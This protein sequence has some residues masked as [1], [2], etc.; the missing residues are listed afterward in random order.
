M[1]KKI[2]KKVRKIMT[3]LAKKLH[4]LKNS[5]SEETATIYTTSTECPEPN[6]KVN[7]DG[8]DGYIKLGAT[9]DPLA[10]QGRV[11]LNSDNTDYA[12]LSEAQIRDFPNAWGAFQNITFT[13]TLLGNREDWAYGWLL[14]F[15]NGVLPMYVGKNATAPTRDDSLYVA[16]SYPDVNS[17]SQKFSSA[18]TD[19]NVWVAA[20]AEDQSNMMVWKSYDG[21][22]WNFITYTDA[23][24]IGFHNSSNTVVDTTFTAS[25]SG[26]VLTIKKNG[27]TF[28]TYNI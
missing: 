2:I 15:A 22:T 28:K 12:I 17:I 16:G 1:L 6:L 18:S 19:P 11:H 14:R 23:T 7:V 20:K 27:T 26:N 13:A 5:G 8:V 21:T 4:I 3:E 9:D 10:T 25:V 24:L